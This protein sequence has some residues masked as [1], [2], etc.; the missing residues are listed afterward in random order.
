[1]NKVWREIARRAVEG[2]DVRRG[3]LVQV[4][5]HAGRP[6]VLQE[7]LFA[8]ESAGATPLPEITPPDYLRELLTEADVGTLS[9][10]DRHRL[11]WMEEVDRILVL[12]GVGLDP[13]D[14]PPEA[15]DAWGEAVSRLTMVEEVRRLPYLL[16][17]IPTQEQAQ[18][19]GVT[20]AELD[21]TVLPGLR[22]PVEELRGEINRVLAAVQGG[23]TLTI[24]SGDSHELRLKLGGRQ[25]LA[26]D[27]YIESDEQVL[28]SVTS[29]LPAGTVYTTVVEEETEGSLWLPEASGATDAVLHFEEGCVVEVKAGA[30]ANDFEELLARH[31][32]DCGRV[33]YIGIGVNPQLRQ[34]LGDWTLMNEAVHGSLVISLG[35]NRSFGGRNESSLSVDYALPRATLL[36][37][38]RLIVE[39]GQLQV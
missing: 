6:G 36:V 9:T 15:L 29:R 18:A 26:D 7:M 3:E 35:E 21:Q 37:D 23:Q 38:D 10:W 12:Q 11:P 28:G 13:T 16:V 30:H 14:L 1:M 4:R 20:L 2:L 31:S 33:G 5:D 17:A 39:E 25:W 8:I 24:R 34:P 27:G 22:A 19:L 32:G